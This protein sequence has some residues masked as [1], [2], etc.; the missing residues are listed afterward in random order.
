MTQRQ[1][2]ICCEIARALAHP[3]SLTAKK[4]EELA[5]KR[6]SYFRMITKND[7]C[8]ADLI[9]AGSGMNCLA[10]MQCYRDKI[11]DLLRQFELRE[12]SPPDS[13]DEVEFLSDVEGI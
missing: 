2:Q 11:D 4:V 3:N 10:D 6:D 5:Q 9:A 8:A 13:A 7:A 1:Q 12:F